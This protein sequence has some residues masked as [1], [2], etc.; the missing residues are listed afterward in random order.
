MDTPRT[1]VGA[2][3]H[4]NLATER[5]DVVAVPEKKDRILKK[6]SALQIKGFLT[7]PIVRTLPAREA[8][9]IYGAILMPYA[10]LSGRIL[11]K[12]VALIRNDK[13]ASACILK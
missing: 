3:G 12:L 9:R 4:I 8:I 6:G 7:N 2:A 11:G 10:F 5:I 1:R 13:D